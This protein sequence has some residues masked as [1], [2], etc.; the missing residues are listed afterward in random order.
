MKIAKIVT[1]AKEHGAVYYR[2]NPEIDCSQPNP[3]GGWTDAVINAAGSDEIRAE[4]DIRNNRDWS[5]FLTLY[6]TCAQA[7]WEEEKGEENV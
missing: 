3:S 7:A 6:E 4:Y 1:D 2:D 5:R